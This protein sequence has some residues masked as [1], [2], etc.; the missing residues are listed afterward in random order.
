MAIRG[1]RVRNIPLTAE[2]LGE[3][4]R[5]LAVRVFEQA[6]LDARIGAVEIDGIP[7]VDEEGRWFDPAMLDFW[8]TL[9]GVDPAMVLDVLEQVS[10]SDHLRTVC[11]D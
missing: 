11:G 1:R 3:G 8:S 5:M 9:A 6:L 4:I 10:K 2:V 7:T